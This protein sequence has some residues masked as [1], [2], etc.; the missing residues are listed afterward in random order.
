MAAKIR[1]SSLEQ[2]I[3]DIAECPICNEVLEDNRCLPCLHMFCLRCL[4]S[5]RKGKPKLK[6]LPCPVCRKEFSISKSV[7]GLPRNFFIDKLLDAHNI[8]NTTKQQDALP[9]IC[10]ICNE[11]TFNRRSTT[12]IVVE[13]TKFALAT[14]FC[15]DCRQFLCISCERQHKKIKAISLHKIID[16]NN[17]TDTQDPTPRPTYCIAHKKEAE[18]YCKDC[19]MIICWQCKALSHSSHTSLD[20]S[21][22]TKELTAEFEEHIKQLSDR[23][24]TTEDAIL[25][26]A[27]HEK[28]YADE[29]NAE[30]DKIGRE[31]RQLCRYITENG[32]K[33]KKAL[34][35]KT[36]VYLDAYKEL[37]NKLETDAAELNRHKV[38]IEQMIHLG[39]VSDLCEYKN[40][41]ILKTASPAEE[42]TFRIVV[43]PVTHL[44][45]SDLQD[46]LTGKRTNID[47][48]I[49]SVH[50]FFII[51][52]GMYIALLL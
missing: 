39:N 47:R 50:N 35:T 4:E 13:D 31:Q 29:I 45:D 30:L 44:S 18:V 19:K 26:I 7:S 49:L 27:Q 43:P 36:A 24:L 48:K 22:A 20:V 9:K 5:Y 17:V 34:S 15:C 14:R 41:V 28:S 2:C 46:L 25:T 8:K 52:T 42:H 40:T 10:E 11:D 23:L 1:P 3:L 12:P 32:D 21:S 6:L 38:Y 16:G 37:R 51:I 33:L